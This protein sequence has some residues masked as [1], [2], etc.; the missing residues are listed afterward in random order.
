MT[1]ALPLQQK[2][3]PG[4]SHSPFVSAGWFYAASTGTAGLLASSGTANDVASVAAD[5]STR[6]KSTQPLQYSCGA[7]SPHVLHVC[8]QLWAAPPV[9]RV[10]GCEGGQQHHALVGLHYV[11]VGKLGDQCCLAVCFRGRRHGQ[12]GAACQ[13]GTRRQRQGAGYLEGS[14]R[15]CCGSQSCA[16]RG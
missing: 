11:L 14:L 9:A 4:S 7:G 16:G 2:Q 10:A 13:E 8:I 5:A 12:A 15:D 1:A 3:P 6:R